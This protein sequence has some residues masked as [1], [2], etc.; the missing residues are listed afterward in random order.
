MAYKRYHGNTGRV[1]RVSTDEERP[2]PPPPPP[3]VPSP[4]PPPPPPTAGIGGALDALL[5]RFDP[6][7][8]QREDWLVLGIL[9]LLYRLSGEGDY[10]IAMGAYLFL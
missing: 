9:W 8:L 10:L 2:I 1:E 6:G 4:P 7:A 3:P 5:R